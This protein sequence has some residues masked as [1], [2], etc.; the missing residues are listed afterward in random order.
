MIITLEKKEF[1]EAVAQVARF[2]ERKSATLP[3]LSGIV[4]LAGDAGIKLRATNLETGID[5]QVP[6]TITDPGVVVVPALVLKEITSSLS[7]TG[8]L[9]LEYAGDTVVISSLSGRSTLKTL[10]YEDFP[11]LPLPEA[12]K[13]KFSLK[14]TEIQELIGSV[15]G[16]ASTSIVRPELASIFIAAEG[17]TIKAVATDSFRLAEKK[18][19]VSGKLPPF[20]ILIP[21]KNAADII[22]TLPNEEITLSLDDH[23]C[24]FMWSKGMLTTRLVTNSYPDYTQIIPK[25]FS[26]EATVLRKDLESTLRRVAVFSDTFQKIRIGFHGKE[27]SLVLTAR[28]TDIGESNEHITAALTGEEIELSFNH[29]Y[30]SAPLPLITSDSVTVS[31]SGLGRATVIRGTGDTSFLYLVMPMN[32]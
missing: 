1:S 23:Q 18:L 25:T 8:T 10:P 30:L 22:Q 11:T 4:I 28:N 2:A 6:G 20:T 5:I 17:G 29:R 26:A 3:V 15:M 19:S 13:A 9:T 32:Q 31:A 7:G 21:A 24:V 16:C 27:K 14:N 12:P